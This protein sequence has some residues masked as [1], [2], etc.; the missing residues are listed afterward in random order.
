LAPPL[1]PRKVWRIDEADIP[2]T[3]F[4]VVHVDLDMT[5]DGGIGLVGS[6]SLDSLEK[7]DGVTF[8]NTFMALPAA[9]IILPPSKIFSHSN[10]LVESKHLKFNQIYIPPYM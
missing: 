8:S 2:K 6:M 3:P 5:R 7:A 1:L 4:S 9:T 10:F